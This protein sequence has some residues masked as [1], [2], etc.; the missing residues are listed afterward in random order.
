MP[1]DEQ[2]LARHIHI[3]ELVREI[4]LADQAGATRA[5]RVLV[6]HFSAA[7][8]VAA[9]DLERA[10]GWFASAQRRSPISRLLSWLDA[11]AGAGLKLDAT[12]EAHL[13]DALE[14]LQDTYF[15]LIPPTPVEP[16]RLRVCAADVEPRAAA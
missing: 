4:M 10:G 7:L 1:V 16:R 2:T 3:A 9:R 14:S 8:V 6:D 5:V 15:V 13:R 11:N 12:W